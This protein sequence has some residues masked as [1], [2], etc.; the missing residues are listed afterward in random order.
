MDKKTQIPT[1]SKTAV[2]PRSLTAE[3]GA[4]GL[5]LGE[6]FETVE[7]NNEDYCGCGECD[8]CD[9]YPDAEPTIQHKVPISWST[10][11]EIYNTIVAHYE[12]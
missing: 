7:V 2:M 1:L 4:K 9:M 8:F 5:L 10:I 11:K 12:A 6:F 3:N